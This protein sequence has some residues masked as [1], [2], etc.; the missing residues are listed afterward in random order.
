MEHFPPAGSSSRLRID[1]EEGG[2]RADRR[3]EGVDSSL[4]V[5]K[6]GNG[7]WSDDKQL[8]PSGEEDRAVPLS[9]SGPLS[10]SG[11]RLS[12]NDRLFRRRAGAHQFLDSISF[13]IANRLQRL[14]QFASG[15]TSG[16]SVRVKNTFREGLMFAITACGGSKAGLSRASVAMVVQ[17]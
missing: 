1:H 2:V 16:V 15:P 8:D 6:Q 13:W 14:G 5:G 7:D 9:C 3:D 4:E 10:R 17:R 12:G 11:V